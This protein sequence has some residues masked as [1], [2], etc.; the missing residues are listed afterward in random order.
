VSYPDS[1]PKA[2]PASCSADCVGYRAECRKHGPVTPVFADCRS[3]RRSLPRVSRLHD[4]YTKVCAVPLA[5][6]IVRQAPADCRVRA[7]GCGGSP[8]ILAMAGP[9]RS[10]LLVVDLVLLGSTAAIDSFLDRP[11]N[12][13]STKQAFTNRLGT[14]VSLHSGLVPPCSAL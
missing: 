6:C 9:S 14:P 12:W 2:E 8:G 11:R 3:D 7:R 4:G 5:K 13:L 10:P 1:R